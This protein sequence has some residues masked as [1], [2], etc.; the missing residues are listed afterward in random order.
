[1]VTA[2]VGVCDGC[3]TGGKVGTILACKACLIQIYMTLAFK[4]VRMVVELHREHI[5]SFSL[6]YVIKNLIYMFAILNITICLHY[7]ANAYCIR[8]LIQCSNYDNSFTL[9]LCY[10]STNLL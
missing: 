4:Y 6:L 2:S 10:V 9:I 5:Y 1:M 8:T 3:Y 7:D